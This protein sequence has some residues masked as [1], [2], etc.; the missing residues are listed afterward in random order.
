MIR[1]DIQ[2]MMRLLLYALPQRPCPSAAEVTMQDLGRSKVAH[3]LVQIAKRGCQVLPKRSA[4]AGQ[5]CGAGGRW[6]LI[7][8]CQ[9]NLQWMNLVGPVCTV[10]STQAACRLTTQSSQCTRETAR[11]HRSS[12]TQSREWPHLIDVGPDEQGLEEG[13]GVRDIVL[14]QRCCVRHKPVPRAPGQGCLTGALQKEQRAGIELVQ[15]IHGCEVN[16]GQ[17]GKPSCRL[18]PAQWRMTSRDDAGVKITMQRCC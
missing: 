15:G 2:I 14:L 4:C 3:L 6:G 16:V 10:W 7:Q 9:D 11:A 17:A 8:R 18:P 5:C 12:C 1:I 13:A